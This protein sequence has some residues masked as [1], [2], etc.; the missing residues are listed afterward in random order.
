MSAAS[1]SI[2]TISYP[3]FQPSAFVIQEDSR[4]SCHSQ[5]LGLWLLFARSFDAV[6]EPLGVR[7]LIQQLAKL[8]LTPVVDCPS[9]MS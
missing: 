3:T 7:G 2:L 6:R 1:L 4:L 8:T 9:L 5:H